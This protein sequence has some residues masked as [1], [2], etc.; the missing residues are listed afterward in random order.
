MRTS[1]YLIVFVLSISACSNRNSM[2]AGGAPLVDPQ[3]RF[4]AHLMQ[5]DDRLEVKQIHDRVELWVHS[6]SGIGGLQL[7]GVSRV[8]ARLLQLRVNLSA[9]ESLVI[10]T[11]L[12]QW[13]FSLAHSG[14]LQLPWE[15]RRKQD[16]NQGWSVWQR[17]EQGAPEIQASEGS[18][19]LSFPLDSL[20][21]TQEV[22]FNWID[23]YR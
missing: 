20:R 13:R 8:Q 19:M 2:S 4:S 3:A 1:L 5:A 7:S 15:T 11:D 23:Y 14:R 12:Q 9:L 18:I 21:S 17:L 16:S 10:K 22:R 6:E